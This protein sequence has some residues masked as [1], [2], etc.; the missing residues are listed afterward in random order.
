MVRMALDLVWHK[1]FSALQRYG[2]YDGY[3]VETTTDNY[4]ILINNGQSCC[5]NWG[6][7][8]TN[9]NFAEFIGSELLNVSVVDTKYNKKIIEDLVTK[10]VSLISKQKV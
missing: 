5:E 8:D 9:D 6:Y 2:D 10:F 1:Q 3:F 7:M 4:Y